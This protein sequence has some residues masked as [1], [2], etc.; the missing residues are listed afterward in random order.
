MENCVEEL[1]SADAYLNAKEGGE[2]PYG[3]CL[4]CDKETFIYAEERC[5]ACEEELE[6]TNCLRCEEHLSLDDQSLDG[7]CSYC[8]YALDKLMG[9]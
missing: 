9:E 1:L 8:H 3:R 6:Y 5:I 7:L 2:P 4:Q